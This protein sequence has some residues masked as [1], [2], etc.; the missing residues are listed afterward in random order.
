MVVMG[1]GVPVIFVNCTIYSL[2][3]TPL[4]QYGM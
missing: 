2:L 1:S 4:C 3:S